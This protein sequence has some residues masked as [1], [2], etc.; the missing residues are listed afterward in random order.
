VRAVVVGHFGANLQEE[1]EQAILLARVLT[2]VDYGIEDNTSMGSEE[3]KALVTAE[4]DAV[5]GMAPGKQFFAEIRK[6]VQFVE[7]GGDIKLLQ[8]CHSPAIK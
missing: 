7:Q 2:A 4:L 8:V 6:K 3:A 5:V 1:K